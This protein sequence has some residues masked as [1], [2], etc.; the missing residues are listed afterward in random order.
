MGEMRWMLCL[1]LWMVD[2]RACTGRLRYRMAYA[3]VGIKEIGVRKRIGE[4]VFGRSKGVSLVC[5]NCM[6]SD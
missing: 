6:M 2:Y 3:T 4:V 5:C 1:R